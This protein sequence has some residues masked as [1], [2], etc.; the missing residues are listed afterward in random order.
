LSAPVRQML[1]IYVKRRAF[2]WPGSTLT[3]R[4]SALRPR[5]MPRQPPRGTATRQI[6][7]NTRRSDHAVIG[8]EPRATA[9][10]HLVEFGERCIG[11]VLLHQSGDTQPATP[12]ATRTRDLEHREPA[13]E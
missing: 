13:G 6:A 5:P 9:H 3:R 4:G 1:L 10:Q 8:I 11:A 7:G 12:R 2:D